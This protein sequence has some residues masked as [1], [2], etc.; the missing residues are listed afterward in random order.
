M[1]NQIKNLEKKQMEVQKKLNITKEI[2]DRNPLEI[3]TFKE[4][5]D[6]SYFPPYSLT[7]ATYYFFNDMFY[8]LTQEP[9]NGRVRGKV[10]KG[11]EKAI[12][13]ILC[14]TVMAIML[15]V[16]A[17]IDTPISLLKI[18]VIAGESAVYTNYNKNIE[19][20][21]QKVL[22]LEQ[23]NNT[24]QREISNLKQSQAGLEQ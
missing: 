18:G 24:I 6:N 19:K 9:S 16:T 8:S 3:S 1:K 17:I 15:P 11:I 20:A 13:G 23:E 21:K 10:E 22:E 4:L 2:A 14:G 5:W 12:V 7:Q